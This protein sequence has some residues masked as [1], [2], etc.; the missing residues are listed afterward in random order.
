[1]RLYLTIALLALLSK[2]IALNSY[3]YYRWEI[4]N[5][6]DPMTAGSIQ[7]AEFQFLAA[8]NSQPQDWSTLQSGSPTN[9]GGRSPSDEQVINLVDG[10][11]ETKWLDFICSSQPCVVPQPPSF[12]LLLLRH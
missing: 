7:A 11:S 10:N 3:T 9:P 5:W 2:T 12:N 4:T 6:R 1:M 8:S